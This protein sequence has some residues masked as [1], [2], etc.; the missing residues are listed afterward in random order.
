MDTSKWLPMFV[1]PPVRGLLTPV[2][3]KGKWV[4]DAPRQGLSGTAGQAVAGVEDELARKRTS[5]TRTPTQKDKIGG[6]TRSAW[7]LL[8]VESLHHRSIGPSRRGSHADQI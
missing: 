3:Q 8:G 6:Q 7:L 5:S 4:L 2:V 1:T